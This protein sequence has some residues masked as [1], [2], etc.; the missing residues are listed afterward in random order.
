[1][2]SYYIGSNVI[3]TKTL[4]V[5]AINVIFF[6]ASV[7]HVKSLI[8]EHGNRVFL[9]QS[10]VFHFG[11]VVGFLVIAMPAIALIFFINSLKNWLM[12]K[13]QNYKP[14]HIGLIEIASS[15][16]FVIVIGISF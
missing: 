4:I 12:L 16:L 14:M 13:R 9:L 6:T 3:E 8:R 15:I 10:I 1:M 2:I 11:T 5:M 7:F